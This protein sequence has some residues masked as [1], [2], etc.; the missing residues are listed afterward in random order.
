MDDRLSIST[1]E[2]QHPV[3]TFTPD[4]A[5]EALGEG[6]GPC[7]PDRGVDDSDSFCREDL[8]E[9]RRELSVAIAD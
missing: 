7:S 3:Q 8:V 1:A 2:D 6:I 9:A 4:G 5:N